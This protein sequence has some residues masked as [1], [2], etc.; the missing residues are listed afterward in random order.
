MPDPISPKQA[1]QA[2]PDKALGGPQSGLFV[3]RRVSE[4][5]EPASWGPPMPFLEE[6]LTLPWNT[7]GRAIDPTLLVG[8]DGKLHCFFVGSQWVASAS[9]KKKVKANLLGHAVTNDRK[10]SRWTIL[11]KDAPLLG[12]SERAK[13]GVENVAVFQRRDG[14]FQARSE[15]RSRV[16]P[17]RTPHS[18]TRA[19]PRH[20]RHSH[21]AQMIYSESL[22]NQHL[23]YAV[24]D[25]LYTWEDRGPLKLAF[26]P[27]EHPWLGGRYGAPY[28]WREPS[29]CFLMAL[30]GEFSMKTA[31][32]QSAIGLLVSD[33]GEGWDLAAA[34]RPAHGSVLAGRRHRLESV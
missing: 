10:L 34:E 7:I 28:V 32:H 24:S 22:S 3:A 9:G 4:P 8:P 15:G 5:G 13:D 16:L 33:D 21:A 29:G 20:P 25:D 1:F 31:Y 30:M 2:Y 26:S 6:A 14:R 23:A 18:F 11:T 17:H 27:A 19:C 12:A